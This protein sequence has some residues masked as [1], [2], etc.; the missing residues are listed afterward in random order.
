MSEGD[1][2]SKEQRKSAA[3]AAKGLRDGIDA[4]KTPEQASETLDALEE[5]SGDRRN[6]DIPE[7]DIPS[8]RQAEKIA[9]KA[10]HM[11]ESVKPTTVLA[12]TAKQVAQAPEENQLVLDRAIAVAARDNRPGRQLLREE[13]LRR[14]GPLDAVDAFGF[15][16][17][18][19]L[20]HPRWLNTSLSK[21][22]WFMTGG[23]AWILVPLGLALATRTS[24]PLKKALWIM[25]S[26]WGATFCVEMPIKHWCRR[27]RPF[28][29]IVQA[30][31]VGRKPGSFSFPSGHSAAAFSGAALLSKGFPRGKGFFYTVA[32]LVAFS[33][34]F[35]G[36]HYPGDV[37]SGGFIGGLLARGLSR[38]LRGRID[39]F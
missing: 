10:K 31:V 19:N 34:I 16:Q 39:K 17:I 4:V 27:K 33:R 21:F 23:H 8:H 37:V 20:P 38:L 22:S 29:S 36:A 24:K 12:E 1:D 30:I 5:V 7:K 14:L 2:L 11:P 35:L 25:P 6:E 9:V 28:I 3:V 15:M 26:L 18:N 13:L 32:G